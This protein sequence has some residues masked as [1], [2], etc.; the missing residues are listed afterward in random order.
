MDKY[1]LQPNESIILKNDKVYRGNT[2]GELVLTNLNLIHITTKGFLKIRYIRQQYPINQIK[3]FNDKAQAISGWDGA[4]D[5]YFMNAQESFR[6]WNEDIFFS[7]KKA[8]REVCKWVNEIN[9]LLT[10]KVPENETSVT[11][12]LIG[13]EFKSGMLKETF[14]IF[15][16]KLGIKPKT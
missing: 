7:K 14:D 2:N 10:G 5:I 15:K 3:V 16:N 6:F 1:D 12:S 8:E 9:Q 11:P 13:M 4:L